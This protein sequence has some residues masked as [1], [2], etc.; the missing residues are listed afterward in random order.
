MYPIFSWT[1]WREVMRCC[2]GL[3]EVVICEEEENEWWRE[4]SGI[5]KIRKKIIS[6]SHDG[7]QV[8]SVDRPPME[9]MSAVGNDRDPTPDEK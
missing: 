8:Q 2:C 6:L 3:W 1:S 7:A 4:E 5:Y 9:E